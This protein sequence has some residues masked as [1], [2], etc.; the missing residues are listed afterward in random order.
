M[1]I[2][3]FEVRDGEYGLLMKKLGVSEV[4]TSIMRGRFSVK[5]FMVSDIS[6]PA[7][8]VVKQEVLSLGGEAAVPSHAVNCSEPKSDFVFTLRDRKSVV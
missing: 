5:T 3:P 7:A 2:F 8:N 4:G 6:T 1:R